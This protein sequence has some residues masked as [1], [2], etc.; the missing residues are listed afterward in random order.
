LVTGLVLEEPELGEELH[1][2][3]PMRMEAMRSPQSRRKERRR[4]KGRRKMPAREAISNRA[5]AGIAP[6]AFWVCEVVIVRTEVP[7]PG[8]VRVA[9][10]KLHVA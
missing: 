3:K 9:G 4:A 5:I 8:K 1:P 10:A 7:L 2:L 6:A